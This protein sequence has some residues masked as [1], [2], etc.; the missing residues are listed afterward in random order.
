MESFG[1]CPHLPPPTQTATSHSGYDAHAAWACVCVC[2]RLHLPAGVA[3]PAAAVATG[4]ASVVVCSCSCGHSPQASGVN[5]RND[6][7]WFRSARRLP[8]APIHRT[9]SKLP[10]GKWG[11]LHAYTRA[12]ICYRQTRTVAAAFIET[13]VHG[14]NTPARHV[15]RATTHARTRTHTEVGGVGGRAA[16]GTVVWAQAAAQGRP[17]SEVGAVDEG[18]E[19]RQGGL[20]LVHGHL[21]GP[22]APTHPHISSYC[23]HGVFATPR[24]A[25]RLWRH[26][27]CGRRRTPGGR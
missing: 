18:G 26:V 22:H 20:W 19:E 8:V 2:V 3:A 24:C 1:E 5:V 25:R 12:C 14:A 7:Y 15:G 4:C 13:N 17:H 27:P 6:V 10:P 16:C 21:P 23:Q 9:L 11:L